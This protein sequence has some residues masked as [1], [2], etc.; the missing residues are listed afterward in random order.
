ML[1]RH[2]L[3]VALEDLLIHTLDFFYRYDFNSTVSTFSHHRYYQYRS[4][5]LSSPS[6]GKCCLL[7]QYP[8]LPHI[9]PLSNFAPIRSMYVNALGSSSPVLQC[10]PLPFSPFSPLDGLPLSR[11][12]SP[13]LSPGAAPSSKTASPLPFLLPASSSSFIS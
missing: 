12:F 1:T 7:P 6:K 9:P 8:L 5:S 4:S 11:C 3:T 2:P 13:S 10:S